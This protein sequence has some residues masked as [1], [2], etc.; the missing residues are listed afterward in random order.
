M[1]CDEEVGTRGG[2][3]SRS[4]SQSAATDG[5]VAGEIRIRCK[6][7]R[8]GRCNGGA[9]IIIDRNDTT[10]DICDD[11]TGRNVGASNR[12]AHS[13]TGGAAHGEAVSQGGAASGNSHT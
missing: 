12:L 9:D 6:G 1:S 13:E 10:V 5:Y 2:R 11:R 3:S 8:R 7:Q 4:N